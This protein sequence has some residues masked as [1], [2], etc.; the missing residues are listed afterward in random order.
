MSARR[1]KNCLE[2]LEVENLLIK[3]YFNCF[4]Q[5]QDGKI[6]LNELYIR[7]GEKNDPHVSLACVLTLEESIPYAYCMKLKIYN[8][9]MKSKFNKF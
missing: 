1:V 6:D 9:E 4:D 8:Y 7:F 2:L 3:Q 5:N